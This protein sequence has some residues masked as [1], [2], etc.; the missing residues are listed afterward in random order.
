MTSWQS[1]LQSQWLDGVAVLLRALLSSAIAIAIAIAFI[2]HS[3]FMLMSPPNSMFGARIN[4]G[5]AHQ[6]LVLFDVMSSSFEIRV[7]WW[8]SYWNGCLSIVFQIMSHDC[9]ANTFQ[10]ILFSIPISRYYWQ[11][12][13]L[14]PPPFRSEH[15]GKYHSAR[16]CSYLPLHVCRRQGS[17]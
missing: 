15:C 6:E 1:R 7:S 2:L 17:V 9:I 3:S 16:V 8:K 12:M 4:E 10:S 13:S 11:C 5:S 14:L